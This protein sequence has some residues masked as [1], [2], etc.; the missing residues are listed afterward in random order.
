VLELAWSA[1]KLCALAAVTVYCCAQLADALLAAPAA[2]AAPALTTATSAAAQLVLRIAIASTVLGSLD[3]AYRRFVLAKSL[4]MTR[5]ELDEEHKESHA[6]PELRA[7][8]SRAF[9]EAQA[10]AELGALQDSQLLLLDAR[11]RAVAL[12]FDRED[13]SQQAP[14]VAARGQGV[15]GSRM[16]HAA[17][18]ANVP[19]HL[20][21]PLV[22]MLFRLE[23]GE[24][25]PALAYPRVASLLAESASNRSPGI[26]SR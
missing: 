26:G 11:G 17:L 1:L 7:E 8:R 15:L 23:L 5:R 24:E 13:S 12:A 21:T 20:D 22:A 25:I 16:Q 2:G 6:A 14:R 10:Q 18:A 9:R 3:L 4:R 19:V